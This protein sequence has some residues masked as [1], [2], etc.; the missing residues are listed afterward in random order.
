[1]LLKVE[2]Q[3]VCPVADVSFDK[4]SVFY[5]GYVTVIVCMVPPFEL[6]Y[7]RARWAALWLFACKVFVVTVL[8]CRVSGQWRE[9]TNAESTSCWHPSVIFYLDQNRNEI[10]FYLRS[11][12]F[13]ILSHFC[14]WDLW[15]ITA[16]VSLRIT[17]ATYYR[18]LRY[19]MGCSIWSRYSAILLSLSRTP[20]LSSDISPDSDV[21]DKSACPGGSVK[22]VPV[23]VRVRAR[24]FSPYL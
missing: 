19:I 8:D 12:A 6:C 1:M 7:L 2:L 3:R 11:V 18:Y 21:W 23:C 4:P 24:A 10:T 14:L 22:E 17:K 9:N 20:Q 13:V 16:G 5:V 15:L